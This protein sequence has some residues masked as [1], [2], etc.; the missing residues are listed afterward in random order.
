MCSKF[1][2]IQAW[3]QVDQFILGLW[4]AIVTD[5]PR[6]LT[7]LTLRALSYKPGTR[8]IIFQGPFG[9]LYYSNCLFKLS[10]AKG[11]RFIFT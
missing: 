4:L 7:T 3:Q 8:E 1:H 10:Y 11:M 6:P 9:L 2:G 5:R